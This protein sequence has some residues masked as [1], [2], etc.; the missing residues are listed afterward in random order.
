VAD[1]FTV[2]V[3]ARA[4]L[5]MFDRVGPSV[6][7]HCR[8]V[9]RDAAKRIVASAKQRVARLTGSTQTNI[10]WA[11]TYD[12]KG[13]VAL[14]YDRESSVDRRTTLRRNPRAKYAARHRQHHVDLYLEYGTKF[15]RKQPFFHQAGVAEDAGFRRRMSSAI[16]TVLDDLGR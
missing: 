11:Q 10:H 14:G 9:A 1:G 13:Y 15:M 5:A 16:Q 3:E 7:F 4:L 2:S 8:E 12:G 6:D